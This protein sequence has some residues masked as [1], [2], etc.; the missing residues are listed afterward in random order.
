MRL[1]S[2][3]PKYLDTKGLVALWSEALLAKKVLQN[4][5]D[6]YRNH[7]QLIRFKNHRF[8]VKAIDKYLYYIFEESKA[9]GFNFDFKKIG[10]ANKINNIKITSG[11]LKFELMHLKN[12]L[13]RRDIN[14][15]NEIKNIIEIKA[16]ALFTIVPESIETWEKT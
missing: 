3:H 5:T 15:Y 8:P 16:N 12:K 6:G 1:W 4:E 9:R 13:I 10:S 2:I 14:K 7:P 11:Q